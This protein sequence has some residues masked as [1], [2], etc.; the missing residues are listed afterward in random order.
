[1]DFTGP[2]QF[3][4]HGLCT[5]HR[6]CEGTVLLL[7][8]PVGGRATYEEVLTL[9]E[10]SC[11]G[12]RYSESLHERLNY[13]CSVDIASKEVLRMLQQK[14][15]AAEAVP[16]S[17]LVLSNPRPQLLPLLGQRAELFGLTDMIPPSQLDHIIEN[18]RDEAT[19]RQH[20]D[21]GMTGD[22]S[23][24]HSHHCGAYGI[25]PI[26]KALKAHGAANCTL[27]THGDGL[28]VKT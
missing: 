26:L 28:A 16:F 4:E 2:V 9:Q 6:V 13:L 3:S 5:S 20:L 15:E 1:M 27:L 8:R 7:V 19:L 14:P 18:H 25:Y 12:L 21:E 22:S 24:A 10:R 11:Q 23:S 17:S